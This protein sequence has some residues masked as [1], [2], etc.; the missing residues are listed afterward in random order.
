MTVLKTVG[1]LT[2]SIVILPLAFVLIQHCDSSYE[3]KL[4]PLPWL[5]CS[6]YVSHR[7]LLFDCVSS[8]VSPGS[9]LI[10]YIPTRCLGTSRTGWMLI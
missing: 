7:E 3:R 6:L 8:F 2:T 5:S 4:V 1:H 9:I 10:T